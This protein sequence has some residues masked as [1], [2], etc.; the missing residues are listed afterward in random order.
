[1]TWISPVL[2]RGGW[3]MRT[4][5]S[6][7]YVGLGGIVLALATY[8]EEMRQGR[9]DEVAGIGDALE[10]ASDSARGGRRR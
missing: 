9:L 4:L 2:G 8:A 10:G 3:Q 1:M 7:L 5:Q 6:N